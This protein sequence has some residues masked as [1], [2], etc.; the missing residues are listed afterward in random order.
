MRA[1]QSCVN[2][3]NALI[4]QG[5]NVAQCRMARAGLGW[6]LDDLA[7]RSGVGRRTLAKYEAGGNVLPAMVEAL[8]R[9]LI[10]AGAVLVEQAGMVGVLVKPSAS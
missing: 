9:A 8:R 5:M 2:L 7:A 1:V 10:D 6:S 4:V 3:K